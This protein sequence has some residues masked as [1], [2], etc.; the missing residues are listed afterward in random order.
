MFGVSKYEISGLFC[1][2]ATCHT[3]ERPFRASLLPVVLSQ[4]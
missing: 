1:I 4:G 2:I 3:S